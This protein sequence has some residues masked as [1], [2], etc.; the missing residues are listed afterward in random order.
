MGNIGAMEIFWIVLLVL[1]I[2]GG[3]KL[4][5]LGSSLGRALFNFRKEVKEADQKDDE[6]SPPDNNS[7]EE[8]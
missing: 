1:I 2:F 6:Q 5:Q 8:K 7:S 4:P 3:K